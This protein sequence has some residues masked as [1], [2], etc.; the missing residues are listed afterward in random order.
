MLE[1]G[2]KVFYPNQGAGLI[3]SVENMQFIGSPREYYKVYM[4]MNSLILYIPLYD[5]DKMGLR[6]LSTPEQLEEARTLFF[7]ESK[8]LPQNS[9][10]RKQLL[11]NRLKSGKLSDLYQVIR[12]LTC[13][14]DHGTKVNAEDKYILEHAIELLESELMLIH[15]LSGEG[16]GLLVREEIRQRSL[17][18]AVQITK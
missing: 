3:K 2:A 4:Q 17:D 18:A 10:D 15:K 1:S 9:S 14:K 6:R 11:K 13:S 5:A 7:A 16:A 12:D 8:Q